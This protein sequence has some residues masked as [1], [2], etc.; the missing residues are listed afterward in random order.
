[1]TINV[2]GIDFYLSIPKKFSDSLNWVDQFECE[3]MKTDA[4]IVFEELYTIPTTGVKLRAENGVSWWKLNDKFEVSIFSDSKK[5][6]VAK[7]QADTSFNNTVVSKLFENPP[8]I[9]KTLSEIAFRTTL[10][11]YQ[12]LVVHA[13]AIKYKNKGI[14]FSGHAEV[15]KSTQANLWKTHMGAK[16]LNGDRPALRDVNG[17]ILVYGTPWSGSSNDFINESAPL[18]AII[19]LEQNKENSIKKLSMFEALSILTPRCFLPYWDENL[20]NLA[21][22]NLESIISKVPIYLL[23]CRPDTEAVELVRQ[24]IE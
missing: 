4:T 23:K 2:A 9:Y 18:S 12:G 1:M 7:L 8:T 15:G 21:L 22:S 16:V 17:E 6:T 5:Q 3:S 13:A 20:M 14:V 10:L 24:C 19:I 11:F